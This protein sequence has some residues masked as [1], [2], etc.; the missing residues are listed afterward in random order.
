[1]NQV[2]LI[3]GGQR[4]IGFAIAQALK[5]AGFRVAIS[6]ER[7]VGDNV[8]GDAVAALGQGVIYRQHDVRDVGACAA[9]LDSVETALGPITTFVSNAGVPARQ[10]R[11]MLDVPP[12]DLEFA[13]EINCR[14]AFA[15]AQEM[16]RR[17]LGQRDEHYRSMVFVT[18]VS[19]EMVSIERAEYCLSKAAAHMMAQ[20]FAA[21]LAAEG[22]GVF[23]IR[24]GI[25]AT[26]MTA[27]VADRYTARIEDGLVPA[28]RWGIPHDIGSAVVPLVT[29]QMAFAHGAIVPVDGGL[30]IP[31]L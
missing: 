9:F 16:A 2:A 6:A 27:A 15:L 31:R 24:P 30:S 5:A 1:M 19:A 7:P 21:R 26:D 12:E 28:R 4:G 18:S 17:M 23:E 8:V 10:R 25:I 14:G 22:I 20:L 3:T 29:G 11:D 13:L